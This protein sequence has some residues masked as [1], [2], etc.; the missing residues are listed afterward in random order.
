MPKEKV[1]N[2][3][4]NSD[5]K[6][7]FNLYILVDWQH[8]FT[9]IGDYVPMQYPTGVHL[10]PKH[11]PISGGDSIVLDVRYPPHS[12]ELSGNK[13][14]NKTENQGWLRRRLPTVSYTLVP[15]CQIWQPP[16]QAQI[17]KD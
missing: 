12:I 3:P 15:D 1:Q 14:R 6:F 9:D 5:L 10:N 17:A 13:F 8:F 7:C 11:Y 2:I 4:K 16:V